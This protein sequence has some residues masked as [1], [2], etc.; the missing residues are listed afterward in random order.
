MS[1]SILIHYKM[2]FCIALRFPLQIVIKI[3]TLSE[4][5]HQ[6]IKPQSSE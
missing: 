4:T 5:E 3:I 2:L 1:E 6:L